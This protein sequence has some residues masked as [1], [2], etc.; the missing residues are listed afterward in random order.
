VK[1]SDV[2][3]AD[4]VLSLNHINWIDSNGNAGDDDSVVLDGQGRIVKMDPMLLDALSGLT[5]DNIDA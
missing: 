4:S 1:K 5:D 2:A 3:T